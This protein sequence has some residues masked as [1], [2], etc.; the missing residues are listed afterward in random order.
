MTFKTFYWSVRREI[1][2]N[3]W[4]F[5]VPGVGAALLFGAFLLRRGLWPQVPVG[6]ETV[7]HWC[8]ITAATLCMLSIAVGLFYLVDALYGER[9]DRSILF[10]KSMP[11]SDLVTVLSKAF[12][13]LAVL[14]AAIFV[15]VLVTQL[16][17]VAVG[18]G[19]PPELPRMT[20][21]LFLGLILMS[22]WQAP[23]QAWVLLVSGWARRAV[24]AIAVLLPFAASL[25]EILVFHTRH[26]ASLLM[27]R[28][29]VGAYDGA[30]GSDPTHLIAPTVVRLATNP[31]L[32]LGLP[33][34][35]LL[36]AA[37]IRM[38]RYRQPI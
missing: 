36:L 22:L 32:W 4:I 5:V 28:L 8:A 15:I 12:I 37:A 25:V 27:E 20:L 33:V 6:E 21:D 19:M 18:G 9:R 24:L 7:G 17:M 35:A 16:L 3:R 26:I 29:T 2:E 38:R 10:W 14:P 11:V 23:L 30:T 31:D 34:A 13:P 1:W